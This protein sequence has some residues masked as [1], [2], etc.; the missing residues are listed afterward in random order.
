MRR[1]FFFIVV[2]LFATAS[3]ASIP[4][5][6]MFDAAPPIA[7]TLSETR[8]RVSD[9][10]APFERPAES[11]LTRALHRGYGDA[12]TTNAS[13]LGR[14]LSVDP[15]LDIKKNLPEPRRWNR[16]AYVTNNPLRYTDPDGRDRYQE[17]GFTKP[18]SEADDWADQ[19]SVSWAFYAQG[20]LLA[21]AGAGEALGAGAPKL[22]VWGVRAMPL[23]NQLRNWGAGETGQPTIAKHLQTA[24]R[25]G[26]ALKS[27]VMHRA[28]TFGTNAIAESGQV[29]KIKGGDG[30]VRTLIQA[31]GEV[32]K[33]SGIF[34][35]MLN[36]KGQVEHQRFIPCGTVTGSP[37]QKAGC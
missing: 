10:L 21:V 18:L 7:D 9:V 23:L 12:S 15:H 4:R 14:F 29:F 19:P 24:E 28:A 25:V 36:K 33:K 37:N 5:A 26:A 3:F 16:Y 32:N 27:D 30:V 17:P 6:S 31:P 20:A 2:F 34:E 8:I 35:Y 22:L 11:E 13:G 1:A